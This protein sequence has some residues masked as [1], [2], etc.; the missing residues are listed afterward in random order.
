MRLV[1]K[2]GSSTL[3]AGTNRLS[4][5]RL[6][7]LVRQI[8]ALCESGHEVILVSS[9]A[10]AAGREA[11][12]YP[13]LP[14]DIPA[15]QMLAAVGQPRLMALYEQLFSLYTV[16]VAQVLL[17]RADLANRRRY[18]NARNTLTALLTRR[19]VPIINENDTVATEE[20]RVGD[21]DNL[22][23][24]VANLV[25]AD[26]LILLTDQP[27]LFTADPRSDPTAQLVAD[28]DTPD[29]PP[30]LWQA[31]SGAGTG[32]GT[33]GM[34]TKLQAADLARR[35]GTLVIIARGS[36]SDILPRL[37]AGEK[38]GTRFQP[39]ATA[40]ESRKRYILT[41]GTAGTLNI[42]DGANGALRRGGSLLPVG[43]TAVEGSFERGD[44]VR[45]ADSAGREIA[46]GIANY[47]AADLVHIARHRSE[48]IEPLLGYNYGDEVIHR[49]D[50]VLL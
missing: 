48:E 20:I 22:S 3:T 17:T 45:V 24:L 49:N 43:V 30:Q 40:L 46:R 5:P 25:D 11:L 41:G 26:T 6:V 37:A 1:L 21:N 10:M 39:V 23:A 44:T 7:D 13:Q 18:L 9:G 15:K 34:I 28:V 36:D 47:S 32:V 8:A 12:G 19:V 14:K 38:I 16:T 27:G 42:G 33:G 2:L 50:L 31:A 35:S 29:L 4:P